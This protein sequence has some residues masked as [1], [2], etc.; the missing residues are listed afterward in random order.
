MQK[1]NIIPYT[2]HHYVLL[3]AVEVESTITKT[4]KEH[5]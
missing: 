2:I 1:S 5:N 4:E 3:S